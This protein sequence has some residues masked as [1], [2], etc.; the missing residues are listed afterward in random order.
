MAWS[1]VFLRG[2]WA[3]PVQT[4][5]FACVRGVEADSGHVA[6]SFDIFSIASSASVHHQA[7]RFAGRLIPCLCRRRS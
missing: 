1:G 3:F 7:N 4:L 5:H 6:F 2:A